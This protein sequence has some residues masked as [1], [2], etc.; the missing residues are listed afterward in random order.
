MDMSY[1][2]LYI[3]RK[4]KFRELVQMQRDMAATDYPFTISSAKQFKA[5]RMLQNNGVW[6]GDHV[7]I[8]PDLSPKEQKSLFKFAKKYANKFKVRYPD[9]SAS[10]T[11]NPNPK[12]DCNS[13][14]VNGGTV[15]KGGSND[16]GNCALNGVGGGA[17]EKGESECR[18]EEVV[19]SNDA[20]NSILKGSEQ[21]GAMEEGESECKIKEVI[22]SNDAENSILKDLEEGGAVE[23][24]ESEGRIKDVGNGVFKG[25]EQGLNLGEVG[26]EATEDI[27][28]K[29]LK[30]MNSQP[31]P[32][33]SPSVS[34][35]PSQSVGTDLGEVKGGS[36]ISSFDK[37]CQQIVATAEI[38][39]E[40]RYPDT[41]ASSTVNSNPKLDCNSDPV[42]GG[43]VEKGGTNDIGNCALN[44]VGGG[45]MEKGESE[46]RIEEVVFSNDAGNSNLKCSEQGGAVEKGEDEC[47]IKEVILSDDAG[48]SILKGL[49]Q[50]GTV[51]KGESEGR[52]KDVGNGVFKGLEQGLN[53]G[54]VGH[55]ASEDI[56][57]KYP[58]ERNSQPSPSV[59][60]SLLPSQSLGTDFGEV[61]GSSSIP[62]FDEACQQIVA[63]AEIVK[64]MKASFKEI[65]EMQKQMSMTLAVPIAQEGR[66]IEEAICQCVEKA[67]RANGDVLL[68]RIQENMAKHEHMTRDQIQWMIGWINN[69]VDKE[70]LHVFERLLKKELAFVGTNITSAVST[71]IKKNISSA[72]IDSV[73]Q[74]VSD[75]VADQ[76]EKLITSKI[77]AT[78]ATQIQAQFKSSAK[79]TFQDRWKFCFKTIV[80]P[81]LERTCKAMFKKFDVI[82]QK[83]I[84]GHARAA[85][86]QVNKTLYPLALAL[87]DTL[88]YTSFLSQALSREL[89]DG[90]G[91][92][93]ALALHESVDKSPF[94]PTIELSR[95]IAE[96]KYEEAFASALQRSDVSIVWWLCSQV[97]LQQMLCIIPVPL[98]QEILLYLL[99]Q[100]ACDISKD[101]VRK[102]AWMT[103]VASSILPHDRMIADHARPILEQVYQILNHQRSLPSTT[104]A[105]TSS[106]RVIMHIINSMLRTCKCCH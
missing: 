41:S 91:K 75:K 106:V 80:I 34:L 89:A 28:G 58:K 97:D 39:K 62:S 36:S 93:V 43:A 90:Q 19:L 51:E 88:D 85:E 54:E 65:Q 31:S 52:I 23:K 6:K 55:E 82:F 64:E 105:I 57:G 45:A 33:P 46:C 83:E 4:E 18:I 3:R 59:S 38:V 100:L 42:S 72:I 53:L 21:G 32:S 16:V 74:G 78:F 24:G 95:L 84:I 37:A 35:S 71:T 10:S 68:A 101:T 103:D 102:L 9:T 22:L 20:G 87:M 60:L 26:H 27:C 44:G 96:Q 1:E 14:P 40:V 2:E 15:E 63:T 73:Q 104:P 86:H 5:L 76:L 49:E 67:T 8:S 92:L 50:G 17:M 66:K 98:S 11:V 30:E 48:N 7:Y 56:C 29:Y 47:R 79:Q 69:L 25:L 99:H 12:L 77:E 81:A 13:D 61:K 70:F 94:D